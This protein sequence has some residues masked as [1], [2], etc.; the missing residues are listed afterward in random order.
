MTGVDDFRQD[1]ESYNRE[2]YHASQHS[3]G[4]RIVW[5]IDLVAGGSQAVAFPL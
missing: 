4:V 5:D 1:R 3:T 2:S